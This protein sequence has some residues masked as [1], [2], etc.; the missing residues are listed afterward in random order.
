MGLED[1]SA[2]LVHLVGEDKVTDW[3]LQRGGGGLPLP[4]FRRNKGDL[5]ELRIQRGV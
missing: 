4:S 1:R 2:A 3:T 5:V